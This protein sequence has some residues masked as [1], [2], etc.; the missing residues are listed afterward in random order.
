M[1][2]QKHIL[3]VDDEED[4]RE[5]ISVYLEAQG[6]RVSTASDAEQ[7]LESVS[8]EQPDL[9]ILDIM[10]GQTDGFTL[11]REMQKIVTVPVIFLSGRAEETERI[12]GLELG[13]DDYVVKPFNPRE[14]LARIRAVLRRAADKAATSPT[15]AVS[16]RMGKWRFD[17]A[18]QELVGEDGESIVLSTGEARLLKVFLENP[19]TVLSRDQLLELSQGRQAGLFDR[20]IDNYIS[21]IRKK[22]EKDPSQPRLI[23]TAWGGGYS[24]NQNSES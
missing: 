13:A 20:S 17:H 18:N 12:I 24:F 9:A 21:R 1:E 23:K 3:L 8:K 4:I 22:I 14:L 5:P 19:N 6:F 10:L 2:T 16:D 7:A 15:Q 11:F